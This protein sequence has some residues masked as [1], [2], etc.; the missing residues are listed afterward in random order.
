[1][2]NMLPDVMIILSFSYTSRK[3]S[4]IDS[5]SE[6]TYRGGSKISK[7][8]GGDTAKQVTQN[9]MVNLHARRCE[10]GT[11]APFAPPPDPSTSTVYHTEA[12]DRE[13][14]L[15][16]RISA[17][18]VTTRIRIRIMGFFLGLCLSLLI[19]VQSIR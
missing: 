14:Q 4:I 7:G 2:Q 9:R 12:H 1:M 8:G 3:T 11:H 19:V 18:D 13:L 6:S 10:K 5:P 17:S 15:M 16:L